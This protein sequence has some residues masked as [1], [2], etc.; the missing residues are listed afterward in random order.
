MASLDFTTPVA[1]TIT[2][3]LSPEGKV[4]PK[5]LTGA[6]ISNGGR[7]VMTL[8]DAKSNGFTIFEYLLDKNGNFI[9]DAQNVPT[10]DPTV[11]EV[12]GDNVLVVSKQAVTQNDRWVQFFW[13][14]QKIL[15][16]AGDSLTFE[17]KTAA[18]VAYF[19]S[20]AIKDEVV[21]EINGVEVEGKDWQYI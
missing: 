9:L 18:E 4:L 10:S 3:V 2:N 20:L 5:A 21:V 11:T 14:Q 12:V 13:T 6:R 15:L 17:A 19:A 16:C 7:K 8:A 1:V